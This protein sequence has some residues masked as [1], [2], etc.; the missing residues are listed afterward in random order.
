MNRVIYFS[1]I[2]SFILFLYV[3]FLVHTNRV[4]TF[5]EVLF[6][7]FEPATAIVPFTVIGTELVIG[8]TSI[9][10]ILFLWWKKKDYVGILTVVVAVGGGNVMNQWLK[11]FEERPRPPFLHGEDGYS[12][13]S[14]HAMVGL[15]FL[16]VVAYYLSK[17]FKNH[18]IKIAFYLGATLL[19]LLTGLSRIVEKAHF[20]SDVLAGFLIGYAFFV[21]CLFLYEKAPR[22]WK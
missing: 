10:L 14:G 12:F 9:L 5:D 19:A 8:I 22:D 11:G 4:E 20:P 13:P 7:W 2:V 1:G 21:L 17:E 15:I 3:F 16:L 6:G 18:H